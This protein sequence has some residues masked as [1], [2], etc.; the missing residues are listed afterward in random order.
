MDLSA[1]VWMAGCWIAQNGT[2]TFEEQWMKPADS[3]MLGMSRTQKADRVIFHEFMRIDT[4][5]ASLVFTPR[6]G[7]RQTPVDFLAAKATSEE[8]VFENAKHDF[9]QR[10]SYKKTADGMTARIE[11]MDGKRAQDF[12]FKPSACR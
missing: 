4:Q 10:I 3:V 8:V 12:R 9:P 2:A 11:T 6:I 1:L 5:G 7:T